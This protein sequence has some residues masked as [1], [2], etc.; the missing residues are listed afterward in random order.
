MRISPTE[1][2]ELTRQ[3]S[4]NV[5]KNFAPTPDRWY[6][7]EN[8]SINWNVLTTSNV[9]PNDFWP[10]T[11]LILIHWF[12]INWAQRVVCCVTEKLH[13][14]PTTF[15]QRPNWCPT[16]FTFGVFFFWAAPDCCCRPCVPRLSTLNVHFHS[17]LQ[18]QSRRK[19]RQRGVCVMWVTHRV[20]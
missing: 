8:L 12:L 20:R 6:E 4:A 11:K 16:L 9:L 19:C 18:L 10:E 2:G 14:V 1:N 5:T 7:N 17:L 15:G 13:A 3:R